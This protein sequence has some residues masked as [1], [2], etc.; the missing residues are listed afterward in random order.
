[1]G[2]DEDFRSRPRIAFFLLIR[3]N[4]C[5]PWLLFGDIDMADEQGGLIHAA[6]SEQIIGAAMTVLN[7]LRP[8]LDEKL[9]ENALTLELFANDMTVQQQKQFPVQYRGHF[10][11]KL[12]PDMIVAEK[13]IVE[14]KV[15]ECFTDTHTAQVLGYLAITNLQLGILLNFKHA[16]LQWK[17]IVR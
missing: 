14:T 5:Y 15:V 8:G 17:R 12:V 13:V 11:G 2:T 1:M 10:I 6:I 3:D 9:Y 16:K 7:E 4:L